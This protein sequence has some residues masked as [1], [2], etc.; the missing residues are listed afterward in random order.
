MVQI[1]LSPEQANAIHDAVDG[2]ELLG[3][4]RR[5]IGIVNTGITAEDIATVRQRIASN[6]PGVPIQDLLGRLRDAQR[7]KGE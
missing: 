1:V 7:I 3:P 5:P 2:I 4:D 6:K